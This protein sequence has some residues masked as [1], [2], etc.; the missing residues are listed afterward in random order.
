[1]YIIPSLIYVAIIIISNGRLRSL[2]PQSCVPNTGITKFY[3][4]I[5]CHPSVFEGTPFPP[6]PILSANPMLVLRGTFMLPWIAVMD[7]EKNLNRKTPLPLIAC[8]K[9]AYI[10]AY[11]QTLF[12]YHVWKHIIRNHIN[13]SKTL[14]GQ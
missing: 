12:T 6:W 5:W 10:F 7:R 14:F 8:M 2:L 4:L 9:S 13:F 11:G 1:M 3:L